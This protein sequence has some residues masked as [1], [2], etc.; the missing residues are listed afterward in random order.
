MH[1]MTRRER[2][3]GQELPSMHAGQGVYWSAEQG[4]GMKRRDFLLTT[5][6]TACAAAAPNSTA[7]VLYAD[8]A[9]ALDKVGPDTKDL[10][11]RRTD[12]PRINEFEVKPQGACRADICIP[13]A[14]D[15]RRG[16]WFNLTGFARK[17]RQTFVADSGVWSFGEIPLLSQASYRSR[18]APDFAVPDRQGSVIHLSDFR[19]KKVLVVT[20]ASW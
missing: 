11:V 6:G 3:C 12:L 10:W 7:T 16:E 13:I 9:V 19:G 2:D 20:W 18:M 1:H 5:A 14:K 15:L 17:I 4:T 8:R